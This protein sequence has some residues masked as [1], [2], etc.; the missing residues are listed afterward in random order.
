MII[1]KKLW[2]SN[3]DLAILSLKSKFVQGIK[4]GNLPKIIFQEYV[5]QDLS[6]I[7]I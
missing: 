3:F 7:H 5:A 4:N 2:E 1:T 6:L